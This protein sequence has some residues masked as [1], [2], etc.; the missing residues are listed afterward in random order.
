MIQGIGRSERIIVRQQLPGQL[1]ERGTGYLASAE[2]V[3][4]VRAVV[5]Q[6]EVMRDDTNPGGS[7]QKAQY[8]FYVQ[9][10][11]VEFPLQLGTH[12]VTVD[13]RGVRFTVLQVGDW[14]G[15]HQVLRADIPQ[16]VT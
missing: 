2:H 11:V 6:R 15:S 3:S 10:G 5:S 4:S 13:Y 9:P 16:A 14:P 7:R 12:P 1:N 8:E